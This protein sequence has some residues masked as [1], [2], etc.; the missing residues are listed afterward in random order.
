[1]PEGGTLTIATRV[2]TAADELHSDAADRRVYLEVSDTGTGMDEETRRLCL[3]PFFATKGE[4]GTGLGLAMNNEIPDGVD[5]VLGKPPK[6]RELRSV[7]SD[8]AA[9]TT[10]VSR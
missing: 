6:L 2:A 10:L 8:L 4:R 9:E 3:E 7:L 5:H 1:M